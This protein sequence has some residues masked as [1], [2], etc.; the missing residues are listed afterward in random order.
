MRVTDDFC[1][2]AAERGLS[3]GDVLKKGM[4][5][6]LKEFLEEAAAVHVVPPQTELGLL[7]CLKLIS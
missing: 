1:K 5:R 7:A 3:E 6:E 2:S 4:Q